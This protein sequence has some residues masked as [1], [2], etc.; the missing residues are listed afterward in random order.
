MKSNQNKNQ[1]HVRNLNIDLRFE[2]MPHLCPNC[3]T[4][5]PSLNL[6]CSKCG[7]EIKKPKV[8][9]WA[10]VVKWL[11]FL[12]VIYF[13]GQ[14]E[15]LLVAYNGIRFIGMPRILNAALIAVVY[16]IF[17]VI[18]FYLR[19]LHFKHLENELLERFYLVLLTILIL[20]SLFY[21]IEAFLILVFIILVG[22]IAPPQ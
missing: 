17:P 18:V 8:T 16:L 20:F 3:G 6:I 2:I 4:E 9:T 22:A 5:N 11:I 14:V 13:L 7:V 19:D 1:L 10:N 21:L 12:F 15:E